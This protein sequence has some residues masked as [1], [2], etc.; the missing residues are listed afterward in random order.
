VAYALNEETR[1]W[2]LEFGGGFRFDENKI[3]WE[4]GAPK[5]SEE[6]EKR[7]G[8]LLQLAKNADSAV[9]EKR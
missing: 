9:S 1:S 4:F 8:V 6:L 3:A 2:I 5:S 7:I